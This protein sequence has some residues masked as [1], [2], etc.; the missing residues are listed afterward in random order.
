MGRQDRERR[1]AKQGGM[2]ELVNTVSSWAQ[3]HCGSW[4]SGVDPTQNC[5][6]GA[7]QA[8]SGCGDPYS[9]LSLVDGCALVI[10]GTFRQLCP[11]AEESSLA[12]EV[13]SGRNARS[14][15]PQV[16]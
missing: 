7:E 8:V 9:C 2:K 13:A 3:S 1:G 11:W 10:L 4:G 16:R 14:Q 6:V 12:L 5:P 15:W